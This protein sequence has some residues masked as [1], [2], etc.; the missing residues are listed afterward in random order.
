MKW[1]EFC[2]LLSGLDPDTPLGRIVQ[3]RIENDKNI[4]DN[5][6]PQQRKIRAEWRNRTAKSTN[7]QSINNTMEQ[8][9]QMFISMSGGG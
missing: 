4:L 1:D 6:T 9:K 8:F 2:A 7:P 3:I 5:F